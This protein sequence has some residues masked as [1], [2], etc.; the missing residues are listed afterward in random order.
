MWCCTF[1]I[2]LSSGIPHHSQY[3]R[4]SEN[5]FDLFGVGAVSMHNFIRCLSLV[6]V[7]FSFCSIIR[8]ISFYT[9]LGVMTERKTFVSKVRELCY[10]NTYLHASTFTWV[11]FS[12]GSRFW[13][14]LDIL[15]EDHIHC[16]FIDVWWG[17]ASFAD[18]KCSVLLDELK[19]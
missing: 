10:L 13:V 14:F 17:T 11:C 2:F 9:T 6:S 7:T 5:I 15:E 4:L 18:I 3:K 1:K 12:F 16:T 19:A 8:K